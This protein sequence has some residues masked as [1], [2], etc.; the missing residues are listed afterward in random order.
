MSIHSEQTAVLLNFYLREH[1][2]W[3]EL[4]AFHYAQLSTMDSFYCSK[5]QTWASVCKPESAESSRLINPI[6]LLKLD[7]YGKSIINCL[8]TS[9]RFGINIRGRQNTNTYMQI[10]ITPTDA[11]QIWPRR[12]ANHPHPSGAE[13]KNA[14]SYTSTTPYVYMARCLVEHQG[15]TTLP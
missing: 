8:E 10:L 14:W 7:T 12:E 1:R 11:K 5:L 13:V 15:G 6:N 3:N 9:I 4:A 2:V